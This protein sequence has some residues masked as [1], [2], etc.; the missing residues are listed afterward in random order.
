[1]KPRFGRAAQR[2][3]DRVGQAGD[4]VVV[5]E[6]ALD[7]QRQAEG[8]QQAV[9]MVELVERLMHQPLENDAERRR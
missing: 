9:E 1:M 2:G 5:A 7:D 4:A 3:G 6:Q 8:Q